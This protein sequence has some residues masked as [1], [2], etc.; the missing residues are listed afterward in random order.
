MHCQRR[1]FTS[2]FKFQ[3]VKLYE[4]GKS[5]AD[6]CK[7]YDLTPSALDKLIKNH[8]NS[9]S[10]SVKD[11]RLEEEKEL[12]ALRKELQRLC[13]ENDDL[14]QAPLIMRRK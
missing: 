10:F 9:G 7:E 8:G 14:K 5:R 11:N 13:M 2:E 6:I 1:T 12:I 3:M 4:N